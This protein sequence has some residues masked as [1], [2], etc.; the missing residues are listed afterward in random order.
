MDQKIIEAGM[1]NKNSTSSDRKQF[2][3]QL[4]KSNEDEEEN[5]DDVSSNK[6]IN[7]MIS[8]SEEEYK[9]FQTMDK[10]AQMI[11]K[12]HE[13]RTGQPPIPRLMTEE[14]LPDWV[15]IDVKAQR[16]AKAMVLE[17]SYGRGRRKRGTVNYN[18]NMTDNEW[19]KV[20]RGS[21]T[22]RRGL[23]RC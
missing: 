2:L 18:D 13:E 14:E 8:R 15:K 19:L 1:F 5:T 11:E 23:G 4:L 7:K 21:T 22:Y 16:E 3:M 10:D 6:S 17:E 20:R 9:L 12:Q